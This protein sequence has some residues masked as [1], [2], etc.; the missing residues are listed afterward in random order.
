MA[1]G[2]LKKKVDLLEKAVNGKLTNHHRFLLEMHLQNIDHLAKQ[3]KKLD[4]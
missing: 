2:K 1:K 3:I 4:E